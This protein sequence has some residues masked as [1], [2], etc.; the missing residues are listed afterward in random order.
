MAE[1]TLIMGMLLVLLTACGGGVLLGLI[2]LL[3]LGPGAQPD[4]EIRE[5][6]EDRIRM[7]EG[8]PR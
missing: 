8:V 3:W 6:V 1:G 4:P 5:W 7:Y 2:R